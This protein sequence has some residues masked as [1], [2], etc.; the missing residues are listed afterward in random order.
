MRMYEAAGRLYIRYGLSAI[1]I[2][3]QYGLVRCTSASDLPEGML[4]NSNRP[5]ILHPETGRV[6][7]RGLP[8]VH[9]NEGD[10]GSAVPQ[11]L[12]H[13]ILL[14]QKMPP[15]TT[16]HDVRWGDWWN[17][18]FVWVF[19]V[20]G[21]APPAHW[22]GWEQTQVYRQPAM[23]F[24]RGG[25][26]C[27]G[28]SKPGTITWARFYERFNTI[29]MDA[30]IGEVMQ[31]PEDEVTRRQNA[32]TNEWPIANVHIPGYDRDQLMSTHRSNHITIC[33][34]NI[35]QELAATAKELGIPVNIVG[36]AREEFV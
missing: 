29:G 20:S 14:K 9:F 3:Y 24:P 22:G 8:I 1:G 16:L 7:N 19:E 25:G 33:Y 15:E 23:Y 2:P 27:S 21:G 4:N 32:T 10:A 13:D 5:D 36:D 28:V 31:L 6:V 17:D 26:T 18:A 35:L 30:G 34:G 12:M 11:V